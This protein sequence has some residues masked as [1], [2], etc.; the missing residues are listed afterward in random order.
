[1]EAFRKDNVATL[2]DLDMMP[3]VQTKTMKIRTTHQ[4]DKCNLPPIAIVKVKRKLLHLFL[5]TKMPQH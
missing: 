3:W 1:M 4:N 2:K 5:Q